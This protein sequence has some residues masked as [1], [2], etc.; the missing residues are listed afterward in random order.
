VHLGIRLL[1]EMK[2]D[3]M[4][5][6]VRQAVAAALPA[7]PFDLVSVSESPAMILDEDAVLHR[8]LSG[9]VGQRTTESV[10][11]ATDAGWLQRAG[12]RCVVFGPG[13][14]RVAHRANEFVPIAEMERAGTVL[15]E[16]IRARCVTP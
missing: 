6:R 2:A 9:L 15:D 4:T 1:P 10:A 3:E 5:E 7:E 11:F 14:I 12:Y 16:L 8:E 13:D